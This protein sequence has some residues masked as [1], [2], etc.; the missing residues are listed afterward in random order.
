M[1]KK[2]EKNYIFIE[3]NEHWRDDVEKKLYS[4]TIINIITNDLTRTAS[5]SLFILF[6]S[7]HNILLLFLYKKIRN[8]KNILHF[9]GISCL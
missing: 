5:T 2:G 6:I 4:T 8:N 1:S 9:T 3:L 7:F